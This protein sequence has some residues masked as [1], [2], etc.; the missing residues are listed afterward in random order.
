MAFTFGDTSRKITVSWIDAG[1][2]AG[3]G[4]IGKK[5]AIISAE[6]RGLEGEQGMRRRGGEENN[7]KG[8]P[9]AQVPPFFGGIRQQ[10]DIIISQPHKGIVK[11]KVIADAETWP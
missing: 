9:G 6:R 11:R 2:R 3:A 7:G 1:G 10:L 4:K 5:S 8:F